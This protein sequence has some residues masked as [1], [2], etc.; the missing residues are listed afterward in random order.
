MTE[1]IVYMPYVAAALRNRGFKLLRV[2]A[3]PKKP[4]YDCYV[5]ERSEELFNAINEITRKQH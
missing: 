1:Y 5:F 3:N 4:Q 2:E